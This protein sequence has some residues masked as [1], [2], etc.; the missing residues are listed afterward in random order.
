MGSLDNFHQAIMQR[1]QAGELKL[2]VSRMAGAE[3]GSTRISQVTASP[4]A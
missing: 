2:G 4:D 3:P 1:V